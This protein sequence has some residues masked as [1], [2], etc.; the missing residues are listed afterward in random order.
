MYCFYSL[1]SNLNVPEVRL[2]FVSHLFD[3]L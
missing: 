2:Y 3:K 1:G